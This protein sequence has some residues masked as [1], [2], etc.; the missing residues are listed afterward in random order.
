MSCHHR[1]IKL[2][3]V[4]HDKTLSFQY[5]AFRDYVIIPVFCVCM[6]S[7]VGPSVGMRHA[8][9]MQFEINMDTEY[10]MVIN[11]AYLKLHLGIER[12]S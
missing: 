5:V 2:R 6:I 9:F 12:N 8:V 4:S 3:Q 1:N 10:I 7:A 11:V